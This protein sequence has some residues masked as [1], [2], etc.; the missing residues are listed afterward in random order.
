MNLEASQANLVYKYKNVKM[1]IIKTSLNIKFIKKCLHNN[2]TPNFSKINIQNKS[3][4]AVKTKSIAQK[5]WQKEEIKQLYVKKDRLN[6]ILYIAHLKVLDSLHPAIISNVM[7]LIEAQ[8]REVV[9]VIISKHIKKFDNLYKKQH[10]YDNNDNINCKHNFYKRVVNY[11]NIELSSDETELI[12]KGLKYNLPKLS[13]NSLL[14]GVINA[15]AAIKCI[16]NQETQQVTRSVINNKLDRILKMDGLSKNKNQFIKYKKELNLMK[17]IKQK[18][19]INKA[20]V[21]KADKGNTVVILSQADYTQKC[22]EFINNNIIKTLEHDPTSKYTKELNS[23]VNKCINLFDANVRH[24]IKQINAQ[25]PAFT[26]L[27]KIHKDNMPIRPLVNYTSAPGYKIARKLQHIIKNSI[28]LENNHSIK[29]NKDFI[30]KINSIDLLPSYKLVSFDIV[31]LYTNI[32]IQETIE[33][34]QNNL[35]NTA[36]LNPQEINEL[37]LILRIV[38]KQNYFTFDGKFFKQGEGLAMGSPLSGLLADIYLNFY[39]NN[40]LLSNCNSYHDKI[41]S[42][43]RYVDDTFMVFNGTCRQMDMLLK[44][45]NNI[46]N[47]IKFT[48]EVENEN[49]LNFLDLSVRRNA[50]CITYKIY[51]KPTTTDITVHADSFHPYTQKMAPFNAFVNRLLTIPMNQ[52]DFQDEVNII[53]HI[54]VN[55]GYKSDIIDNLIRKHR[56]KMERKSK[57]DGKKDRYISVEYANVIPNIIKNELRKLDIIVSFKT[58]DNILNLSLIHI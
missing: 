11:T 9:K 40:Y 46:N 15:E 1:K 28:K 30:N 58:T 39:E 24:H 44:Y 57:L 42:Y 6:R 53:K 34:L 45:M 13:K 49:C 20:I 52:E 56:N 17:T 19:D 26:G 10:M 18:I 35:L 54:A 38:L 43:T 16:K 2:I 37:I 36:I 47:N 22:Y 31:N 51:R 21:T 48:M 5:I 8:I 3:L 4:A 27:P 12:S 32:P 41:I 50:D 23:A 33:I 55:N 14:R 25:A 7:E 29:N